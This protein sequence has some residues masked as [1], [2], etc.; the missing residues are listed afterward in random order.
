MRLDAP[1]DTVPIGPHVR[2]RSWP[3]P[4]LMS[5]ARL[6][7]RNFRSAAAS[8]REFEI[9]LSLRRAAAMGGDH[10]DVRSPGKSP[11][12]SFLRWSLVSSS[13]PPSFFFYPGS[14]F[15][16]CFQS[17]HSRHDQLDTHSA[18]P[19]GRGV[20]SG[21]SRLVE[22]A[23]DRSSKRKWTVLPGLGCQGTMLLI[24]EFQVPLFFAPSLLLPL[25][26]L[27]KCRPRRSV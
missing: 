9:S 21:T 11:R 27:M 19:Q 20:R 12:R 8:E 17:Q 18:G 24:S 7:F 22:A 3:R 26:C 16:L 10:F 15:L 25:F 23:T 1:N 5:F 6:P 4:T 2:G 13:P 14:S